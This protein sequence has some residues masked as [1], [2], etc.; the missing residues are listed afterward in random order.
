MVMNDLGKAVIVR[1][2]I[3]ESENELMGKQHP[4]F[5]SLEI[6]DVA[7]GILGDHMRAT[8]HYC[9]KTWFKIVWSDGHVYNGRIDVTASHCSL[10]RHVVDFANYCARRA[11]PPGMSRDSY[12]GVLKAMEIDSESWGQFIDARE[13]N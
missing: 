3:T 12:E 1:V 2:E 9:Y 6:A 7:F 10:K 5:P 13:F 11:V 8:G 4:D